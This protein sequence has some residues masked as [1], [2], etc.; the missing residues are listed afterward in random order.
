[1]AAPTPTADLNVTLRPVGLGGGTVI[2][3][4]AN[5]AAHEKDWVRGQ[6]AEEYGLGDVAARD[7]CLRTATSTR[8][9]S[10]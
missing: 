3:S 6:W 4:D 7:L 8:S 5:F 10:G 2:D 9:G 1:M